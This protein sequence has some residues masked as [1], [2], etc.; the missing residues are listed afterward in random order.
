MV[1]ALAV[2]A[3]LALAAL[4]LDLGVVGVWIALNVLMAVRLFTCGTRFVGRRW[5]VVGA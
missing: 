1:S 5:A 3:P 2:F 4:A